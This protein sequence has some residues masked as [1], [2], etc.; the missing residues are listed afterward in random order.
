[1]E[2][3]PENRFKGCVVIPH[4]SFEFPKPKPQPMIIY[5]GQKTSF[6]IQ[7]VV[8]NEWRYSLQNDEEMLVQIRDSEDNVVIQKEYNSEAVDS[9][10]KIIT[11]TINAEDTSNIPSGVYYLAAFVDGYT[12]F[13]AQKIEIRKVVDLK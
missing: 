2:F 5:K 4:N 6:G 12:L 8:D 11:V 1:M 9:E 10:D 7:L 3:V 13:P